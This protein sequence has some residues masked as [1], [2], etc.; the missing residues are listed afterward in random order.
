MLACVRTVLSEDS[1]FLC[2]S[3]RVLEIVKRLLSALPDRVGFLLVLNECWY[4]HFAK[5]YS[6]PLIHLAN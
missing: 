3:N 5:N 6:Q 4:N 2:F 1:D